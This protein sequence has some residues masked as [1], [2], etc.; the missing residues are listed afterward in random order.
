MAMIQTY[1]PYLEVN[2]V[3]DNNEISNDLGYYSEIDLRDYTIRSRGGN[4]ENSYN[5]EMFFPDRFL[6]EEHICDYFD[7]VIAALILGYWD[8]D[9]NDTLE[10]VSNR[11]PQGVGMIGGRRFQV[12]NSINNIKVLEPDNLDDQFRLAD[13][14]ENCMVVLPP[15]I[16]YQNRRPGLVPMI[17]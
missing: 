9:G 10:D 17:V 3:W 11:I 14:E 8:L 6:F 4:G 1:D 2:W 13:R 5:Q 16:W 12:G 15:D 7:P